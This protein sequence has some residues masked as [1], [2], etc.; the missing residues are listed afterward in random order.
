MDEL[1]LDWVRLDDNLH[2]NICSFVDPKFRT[3]QHQPLDR[4]ILIGYMG[5]WLGAGCQW[6]I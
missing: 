4:Y 3:H 5:L 6:N 2:Q 1:S